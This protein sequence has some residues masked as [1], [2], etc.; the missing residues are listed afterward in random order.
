MEIYGFAG[1]S[2]TGKSHRAEALAKRLGA[3]A[4]IDDGLLMHERAVIAGVSAKLQKTK[5]GSVRMALFLEPHG[6]AARRE[7]GAN[8]SKSGGKGAPPKISS[9]GEDVVQEI[10]KN[11]FGKI[12]ILGTSERMVRLIVKNLRLPAPKRIITIDEIASEDERRAARSERKNHGRHAVAIPTVE[13]RRNL[14]GL[15]VG[16]LRRHFSASEISIIRPTYSYLGPFYIKQKAIRQIIML[17][18][19]KSGFTANHEP[20]V[21]ERNNTLTISLSLKSAYGKKIFP[22]AAALQKAINEQIT[23]MTAKYIADINV[24][25]I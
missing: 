1:R 13:T 2:G 10:K 12:L 9:A 14:P 24:Q 18:I 25:V 3:D 5:M 7:V 4:I 23:S 15:F 19:G 6:D 21:N 8:G 22:A 17:E 16:S 20:S 11:G